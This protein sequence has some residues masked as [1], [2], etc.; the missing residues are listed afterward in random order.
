MQIVA[1]RKHVTINNPILLPSNLAVSNKHYNAA[2]APWVYVFSLLCV[3]RNSRVLLE[4]IEGNYSKS[5]RNEILD[6]ML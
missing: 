3:V 2:Y 6:T 5:H 4:L 1:K